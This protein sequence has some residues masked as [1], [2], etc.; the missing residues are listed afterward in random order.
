MRVLPRA[1]AGLQLPVRGGA[2][3][4]PL[5]GRC[6]RRRQPGAG[7]PVVQPAQGR[8]DHR[9]RSVFRRGSPPVRPPARSL[10]RPLA[11]RSRNRRADRPHRHRPRHRRRPADERRPPASR[12]ALVAAVGLVS[13]TGCP[14]TVG[15]KAA[16]APPGT[17]AESPRV[18]PDAGQSF[19]GAV[20]SVSIKQDGVVPVRAAERPAAPDGS[21]RGFGAQRC[22]HPERCSGGGGRPSWSK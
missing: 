5:P 9:R 22:V 6:D 8:P 11:G 21:V 17:P 18:L 19:S 7:V 3:R 2:H 15:S 16:T 12:P 20:V 1:G 14:S 13:L 4:A 10:G